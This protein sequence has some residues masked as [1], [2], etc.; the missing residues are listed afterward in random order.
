MPILS[1]ALL[2]SVVQESIPGRRTGLVVYASVSMLV[3]S[4]PQLAVAAD[5]CVECHGEWYARKKE[6]PENHPIFTEERCE[7]CH[8]RHGPGNQLVLKSEDSALCLGCHDQTE[9]ELEEKILHHP[10]ECGVCWDC[11]DPH[12]SNERDLLRDKH[13]DLCLACH[14]ELGEKMK[15]QQLHWPAQDDCAACH[16]P[17]GSHFSGLLRGSFEQLCDGCH[18]GASVSYRDTHHGIP[19]SATGCLNCHDPHGSKT[20]DLLLEFVHEPVRR[21]A[22]SE[23]HMAGEQVREGNESCP[24][25]HAKICDPDN[26]H[27]PVQGGECG[28][29]HRKHTSQYPSLLRKPQI[30]ICLDCHEEISEDLGKRTVH[31][32]FSEGKC[33][34][35]HNSHGSVPDSLLRVE[36]DLVCVGCHPV[37]D[38]D[39]WLKKH[40]PEAQKECLKCHRPHSSDSASLLRQGMPVE[41]EHE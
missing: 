16:V 4:A 9:D 10:F 1:F 26:P 39:E 30:Q 15:D 34:E 22:C 24:G 8:D 18:Q 11:H 7:Y 6:K 29:C 3:L 28:S 27:P 17:H 25:C 20:T 41:H 23:C 38:E 33:G 5:S 37:T 36:P 19:T 40:T 2:I 21:G 32:V 35:C 13:K 14:R 31:S 12:A